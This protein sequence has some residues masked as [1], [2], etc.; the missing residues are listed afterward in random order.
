MGILGSFA[1]AIKCFNMKIASYGSDT[2]ISSGVR[3]Y[4]LGGVVVEGQFWVA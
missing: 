1:S 3:L 4:R 2:M